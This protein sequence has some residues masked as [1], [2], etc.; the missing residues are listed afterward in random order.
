MTS[1]C[2]FVISIAVKSELA[3][4]DNGMGGIELMRGPSSAV[5]WLP[6]GRTFNICGQ[7]FMRTTHASC[8]NGESRIGTT[9]PIGAVVTAWR[10]VVVEAT[11]VSHSSLLWVFDGGIETRRQQAAV[12]GSIVRRGFTKYGTVGGPK[13]NVRP[14]TTETGVRK[15]QPEREPSCLR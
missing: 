14:A 2:L 5:W 7:R 3:I 12:K 6:G 4:I 1:G 13:S 11:R 15:N 8:G 9:N 10:G